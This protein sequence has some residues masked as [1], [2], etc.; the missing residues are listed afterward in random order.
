M[1]EKRKYPQEIVDALDSVVER[2][3]KITFKGVGEHETSCALCRICGTTCHG[4]PIYDAQGPCT[5]GLYGKWEWEQSNGKV[6]NEASAEAA[7]NFY[8]WLKD[9]RDNIE[10]EEKEVPFEPFTITI[11]TLEQAQELWHRANPGTMRADYNPTFH[12]SEYGVPYPEISL[13]NPVWKASD[14]ALIKCGVRK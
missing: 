5:Q 1:T 13:Y 6:H 7:Y 11:E 10:V 3:F 4:C 8:K 9:L 2:W 14:N 12:H